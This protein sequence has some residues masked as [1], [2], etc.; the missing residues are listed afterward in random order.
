MAET[1]ADIER[2]RG[3]CYNACAWVEACESQSFGRDAIDFF[4][5]H[6]KNITADCLH[7][8]KDL[9]QVIIE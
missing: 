2:F 5:Y 4:V 6:R 3:T 8:N 9:A 1:F 7:R